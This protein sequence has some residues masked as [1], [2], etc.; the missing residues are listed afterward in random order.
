MSIS[1]REGVEDTAMSTSLAAQDDA[2]ARLTSTVCSILNSF[3]L[4]SDYPN[5]QRHLQP[6][7]A[8]V[9]RQALP[10]L[11]VVIS[12]GGRKKPSVKLFGTSFWPDVEICSAD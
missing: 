12:L 1:V 8:E 9:L 4:R 7:I 6:H 10:D 3:P 11:Q 2:T 5:E